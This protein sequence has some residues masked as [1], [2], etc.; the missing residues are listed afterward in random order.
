MLRADVP[1]DA[2]LLYIDSRSEQEVLL[3]VGLV[4]KSGLRYKVKY[5]GNDDFTET[6]KIG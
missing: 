2:V 5:F 1:T 4:K 6:I 3:D